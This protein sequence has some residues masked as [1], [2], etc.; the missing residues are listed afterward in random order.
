VTWL[1][2]D[3]RL[4]VHA[5]DTLGSVD[6][7]RPLSD[8]EVVRIALSSA[9][10]LTHEADSGLR[11]ISARLRVSPLASRLT[12]GLTSVE[13]PTVLRIGVPPL[14]FRRGDMTW[15]R[16]LPLDPPGPPGDAVAIHPA[17]PAHWL[18]SN[19]PAVVACLT[20][21]F[22]LGRVPGVSQTVPARVLAVRSSPPR[23]DST[24]N[25]CAGRRDHREWQHGD[26]AWALT[27]VTPWDLAADDADDDIVY[28]RRPPHRRAQGVPWW[29]LGAWLYSESAPRL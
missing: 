7:T 4:G 27:F 23:E 28:A 21:D 26:L 18:D 10:T 5:L 3:H 12:M 14:G 9:Y 22:A 17:A 24:D 29:D 25:P 20:R 6:A 11:G 2:T 1:P 16:D 15:V 13:R 8:L 19:W